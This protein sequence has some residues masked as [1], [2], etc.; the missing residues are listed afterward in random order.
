MNPSPM[1]ISAASEAGYAVGFRDGRSAGYFSG[2]FHSLLV[3]GFFAVL[4]VGIVW[5]AREEQPRT[6][7]KPAEINESKPTALAV[8]ARVLQ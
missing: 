3:V 8:P 5:L 7:H 2:A 6:M 4:G 1:L